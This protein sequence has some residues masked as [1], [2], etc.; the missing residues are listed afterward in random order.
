MRKHTGWGKGGRP[1]TKKEYNNS[2][3]KESFGFSYTTYLKKYTGHLKKPR[4]NKR[5]R[6]TSAKTISY[7]LRGYK[8]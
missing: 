8:F 5:K 1:F 6:T 2:Y 3:L 4:K 7:G